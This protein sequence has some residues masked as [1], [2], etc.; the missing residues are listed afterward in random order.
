MASPPISCIVSVA[1][2]SQTVADGAQMAADG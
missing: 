1:T 2:W